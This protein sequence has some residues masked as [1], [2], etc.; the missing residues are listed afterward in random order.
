MWNW[1]ELVSFCNEF[2]T[3]WQLL[4]L[5]Y[6]PAVLFLA[7]IYSSQS[8]ALRIAPRDHHVNGWQPAFQ[9]SSLCVLLYRT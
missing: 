7:D 5:F 9:C 1:P 6:S 3:A 2:A 8:S 4:T